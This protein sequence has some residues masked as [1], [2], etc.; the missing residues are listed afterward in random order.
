MSRR[1]SL[2]VAATGMQSFLAR[3]ATDAT[4]E[5]PMPSVLVAS[6]KHLAQRRRTFC[7]RPTPSLWNPF[8]ACV[9]PLYDLLAHVRDRGE[10]RIGLSSADSHPRV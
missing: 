2:P 10:G 6:T 9:L 3:L 8:P 5:P 7:E 4:A 1:C